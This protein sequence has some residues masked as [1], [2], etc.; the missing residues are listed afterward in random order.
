MPAQQHRRFILVTL[1]MSLAVAILTSLHLGPY[2]TH[3]DAAH[4]LALA[5]GRPAMLPF[6]S[7]Q[8]AP[9]IA[10]AL[11]PVLPLQTAIIL[12]GLACLTVFATFIAYLLL[13]TRAPLWLTLATLGLFF[14]PQQFNWLIFPDL[15]FAALLSCFLF[16]LLHRRPTL[17]ALLLLPLTL[18]RE[19]ALL[20]L[21]CFLIALFRTRKPPHPSCPELAHGR[22]SLFATQIQTPYLLPAA[23]ALTSTALALLLLH[24]LTR[25]ALPNHE[26]LPPTLYL[27]AKLPWNLLK[28]VLGITPWSNLYPACATPRWQTPLHLSPLQGIG[29]C[30]FDVTYPIQSLAAALSAFGLLPLLLFT[31]R[32]SPDSIPE[33]TL[34]L[35]FALLYGAL[36]FLLAPLLGEL[37]PRLYAYGWPLFL[38]ALPILLSHTQA[39]FNSHRAAALFVAMHLTLSWSAIYLYPSEILLLSAVLYPAASLLLFRTWHSPSE[40]Q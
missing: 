20:V 26:R 1:T 16:A 39:G 13:R 11:T 31:L 10:Q 14:W 3:P 21:A 22:K 25:N 30:G 6:A 32:R 24:H 2:F 38:V 8:L 7:R 18:T 40:S 5:Q 34:L 4:Y 35:R 33:P 29:L 28:N 23:T 36:S 12:E 37:F 27:L 19:S 15:L 17:A 9:L